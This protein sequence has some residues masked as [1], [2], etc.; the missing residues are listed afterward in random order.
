VQRGL[1]TQAVL[2]QPQP[3][4]TFTDAQLLADQL[5]AEPFFPMQPDGPELFGHGITAALPVGARPPRGAVPS[6]L[7]YG[8][9]IHVNTSFIIEVSTPLPLKS[10]S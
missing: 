8:L 9:F 4:A 10:V 2:L 3:Q 7:C 6:R 1:A 5:L